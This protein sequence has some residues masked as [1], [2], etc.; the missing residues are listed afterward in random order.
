MKIAV[1]SDT[2]V[3]GGGKHPKKLMSQFINK[4]NLGVEQ[5]CEILRPRLTGVDLIIHA[6]DFVCWP[7]FTAL[8]RFAPVEAVAGNMDPYEISSRLPA[9]KTVEAAG[10]KIGVIHGW[11]APDGLELKVRREFDGADIIVFGH[12]HHPMNRVV[13]NALMLNP[14]SPT[15]RRW[16][17]SRTMGILHLE[18]SP[19]FEI[20]PLD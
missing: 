15:D 9:K 11:G 8:E 20:V 12:T 3:S 18:G 13:D 4:V 6:G 14:G 5:L 19:R 16:A 17:P 2:H 7:M 10:H 1:L